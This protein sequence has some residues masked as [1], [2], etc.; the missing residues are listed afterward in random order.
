MRGINLKSKR[1]LVRLVV[2]VLAVVAL[3]GFL[4]YPKGQD[5]AA[6]TVAGY[7]HALADHD[8]AAALSYLSSSP[9]D[10]TWLTDAVLGR[11][12]ADYPLTEIWTA[13][14]ASNEVAFSYLLGGSR[15][16]GTV[17]LEHD[18]D[19]GDWKLGG[20]AFE[21]TLKHDPS[22]PLQINGVEAATT[23][24]GAE[25]GVA[26]T[27]LALFPGVYDFTTGLDTV[28]YPDQPLVIPPLIKVEETTLELT[29]NLTRTGVASVAEAAAAKLEDCLASTEQIPKGCG[30]PFRWY[31]KVDAVVHRRITRAS[32]PVEALASGAPGTLERD[33]YYVGVASAKV[34]GREDSDSFTLSKLW[35]SFGPKKLTVDFGP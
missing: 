17:Y 28:E 10:E 4:V 15:H 14:T 21:T 32:T 34:D 16:S 6:A 9:A 12:F 20:G 7:L 25:R 11:A 26:L 5:E 35:I 24:W 33:V 30:M 3:L 27:K 23:K 2:G 29:P 8:A 22:I 18:Y 1:V 19:G 13:S 31:D